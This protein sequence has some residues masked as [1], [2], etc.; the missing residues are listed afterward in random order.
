VTKEEFEAQL[1]SSGFT[2]IETK[3]LSPRPANE[4]HAHAW[5]VR[6]LVLDGEFVVVRSGK[7]V[8]YRPGE[9]FDVPGGVAHSEE[10]GRAGA[11]IVVGR[12]DEQRG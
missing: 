5:R 2:G 6:G 1:A 8:A 12:Q 4:E 3:E 9:I 11:R 7:R 10:I